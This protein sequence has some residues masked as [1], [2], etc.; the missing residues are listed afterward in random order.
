MEDGFE[1]ESSIE[2]FEMF[3]KMG[4][5]KSKKIKEFDIEKMFTKFIQE[6]LKNWK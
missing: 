3:K 1:Q 4:L 6:I 5:S 2:M